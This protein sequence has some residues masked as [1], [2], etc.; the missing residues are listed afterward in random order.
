MN[1]TPHI[2]ICS[3]L[4][5]TTVGLYLY[6]RWLEN[7]EDH[8]IHLHNDSHDS[9][10]INAQASMCKRCEVVDKIKYATLTATILYAV[11]IAGMATYEAWSRANANI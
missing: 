7:H 3:V 6:R 8:Y 10:I 11:A 1:L 9:A 5:L 2:L 4:L